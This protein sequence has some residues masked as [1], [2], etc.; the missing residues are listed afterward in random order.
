MKIKIN[1][2]LSKENLFSNREP[3]QGFLKRYLK[4]LLLDNSAK[5]FLNQFHLLDLK[6]PGPQ[7]RV[8]LINN[9]ALAEMLFQ[10]VDVAVKAVVKLH[11][12]LG[13]LSDPAF[14]L[15]VLEKFK[16]EKRVKEV[17]EAV[18]FVA[19]TLEVNGDVEEVESALVLLIYF[20]QHLYLLYV[21]RNVLYA[22]AGPFVF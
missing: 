21:N 12:L 3:I 2:K 16:D 7:V 8:N 17:N 9:A 5:I 18:G 22:D 1:L 20:F 4:S 11:L 14:V 6:D 19:L 15:K 10:L 13:M